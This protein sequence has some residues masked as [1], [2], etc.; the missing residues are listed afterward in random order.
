MCFFAKQ[1]SLV[2]PRLIATF[3]V[4]LDINWKVAS[5]AS[6][7]LYITIYLH[8]H[9][10]RRASI[11]TILQHFPILRL[12]IICRLYLIVRFCIFAQTSGWTTGW[13]KTGPLRYTA[14][15]FK[16]P[17]PIWVLFFGTFQCIVL[18]TSIG[19]IFIKFITQVATLVTWRTS[20]TR[21]W[22]S[23]TATGILSLAVEP[24]WT[25]C[26]MQ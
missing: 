8:I 9:M 6:D 4:L 13:P 17:E 19:S 18:N 11:S 16:M 1:V 22:F 21:F 15:V 14:H 24:V 2:S 3:V 26:W 20:T 5:S 23:T 25:Y 7:I 10:L 12:T